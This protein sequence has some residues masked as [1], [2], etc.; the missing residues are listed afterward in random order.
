MKTTTPNIHKLSPQEL[1]NLQM[2]LLELLT[3]VDRICRKNNINYRIVAGTMLGAVR[4][5]GFIPWDDDADISFLRSEY[6]QFI[7]ACKNDLD[8]TRFYFQDHNHTRGYRWGFG[9]L[10][11]KDTLFLRHGQEHMPYEQGVFI[12]LFP[13]DYVPDNYL[14]RCVTNFQCFL[15]RKAFWSIVGKHSVRGLERIAYTILN[16]IPANWLYN[17]FNK[18]IKKRNK[19]KT[20]WVR[21]LTYPTPTKDFAYKS[22]WAYTTEEINFEGV[23]LYGVKEYDEYM[24]FKFGNYMELP[25]V[26]ERKTH[27]VS[28]LK[29][30]KQ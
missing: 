27:P 17:H 11:R 4:H 10:R 22:K 24:T 26:N 21:I 18:F 19:K 16:K 5:G 3:E 8:T 15:Y 30:I 23:P 1:R 29:L 14:L 6:E 13:L 28:K 2:I 12:D 25:P 9:K 20:Q 7:Q